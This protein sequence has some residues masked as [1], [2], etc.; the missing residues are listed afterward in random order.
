M[1]ILLVEDDDTVRMFWQ[2]NLTRAGYSVTLA[3]NVADGRREYLAGQYDLVLSDNDC[4]QK[5]VGRDW[6]KELRA[7]GQKTLLMSGYAAA[8]IPELDD[9]PFL[10]KGGGLQ[11]FLTKVAEVL[12]DSSAS[13]PT[14][15][16]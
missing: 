13:A 11:E 3:P 2:R 7:R 6:L 14:T 10:Q 16:P 9:L 4:P 1:R 8:D 5:N 15:P 12:G